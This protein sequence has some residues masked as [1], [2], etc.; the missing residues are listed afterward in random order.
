MKNHIGLPSIG[1]LCLA[2]LLAPPAAA[3]LVPLGPE[4]VVAVGNELGLQ[5]PQVIGHAD[6]SFTV[7]WTENP[8][9]D[10]FSIV[11]QRYD[12]TG[13]PQGGRIDVDSGSLQHR[14]WA[15][16]WVASR[17]ALGDIVTWSSYPAISSGFSFR[18]DSRILSAPAPVRIAAP[19]YVHRLFPR[20]GGGYLGTWGTT[21]ACSLAILDANGHLATPA[22]RIAG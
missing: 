2:S 1:A 7:V 17:G 5:C 9:V 16:S 18:F 11:A 13:A 15:E 22:M 4:T 14:R 21:N 8:Q 20:T 3:Q 12:G 19:S 10:Q 6:R